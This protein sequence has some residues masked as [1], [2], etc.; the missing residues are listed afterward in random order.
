MHWVPLM[1]ELLHHRE[2]A[3]ATL[4][5]NRP[6]RRN[7]ITH[8]LLLELSQALLDCER[9]PEVRVVILSGAG[10]TFCAGLDL[11]DAASPAGIASGG[12]GLGPT[13][14]RRLFPPCVLYHMDTPTLCAING[15]A[16]G[17]GLDLALACDIRFA[18]SSARLAAS[19]T[20]RGVVPES[21]GTWHLPRLLGWSRAAEL[22]FAGRT[23]DAAEAMELGLV[24]RL[25][26]PERLLGELGELAADIAAGAPLAVQAAKRMMRA[27]L[28]EGFDEHIERAYLQVLPLLR[29]ED[30]SE[31]V[32]AFL[33]KR[34]PR[35]RGR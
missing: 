10:S 12:F 1:P 5:L 7:T 3:I 31:G 21:G 33:D 19:F 25:C 17:F 11:D 18:S 4:L 22:V 28:V 20:R 27:A 13:L 6:E 32:A 9:D 16:A 2:G 8:T 35:F 24:S 30:F 29:S 34:E 15:G 14:D 23:L 26:E